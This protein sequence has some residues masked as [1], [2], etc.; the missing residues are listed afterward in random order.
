MVL[1]GI[2]LRFTAEWLDMNSLHPLYPLLHFLYPFPLLVTSDK[3]VAPGWSRVEPGAGFGLECK[4]SKESN[5]RRKC[6]GILAIVPRID[7][8]LLLHAPRIPFWILESG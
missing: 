1:F 8:R 5:L 6:A 2:K 7:F 4:T 3:G